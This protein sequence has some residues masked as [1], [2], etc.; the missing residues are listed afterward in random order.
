MGGAMSRSILRILGLLLS[1]LL[2]AASGI[3]QDKSSS[4]EPIWIF[5]PDLAIRNVDTADLNADGTADII[6]SEYSPDYYGDPSR[7]VALDGKTGDTLWTYLVQDGIRSLATG[8]INADGVA[9]VIAGASYHSAPPSD[10]F[11]HAIDGI[12]GQAIWTYYIGNS[13]TDITLANLNGDAYIDV[14]VASFDDYIH[15]IDGA[16]GSQLWK[17]YLGSLWVNAVSAGDVNGDLI[18]DIG[19]AHEYLAGYDNHCGV[20]DGSTGL[21]IWDST[22]IYGV[23]DVL[24]TDIDNDGVLEA[25]FSGEFNDDHAEI[26]IRNGAD[27]SLEW[28]YNLGQTS[29]L[30]SDINFY[31]YD[32]DGNGDQE[33][34]VANQYGSFLIYAFEGDNPS[35][36]WVSDTLN[37]YPKSL[38]FGD[39]TG[40]GEINIIAATYDRVQVLS[41]NGKKVW[42]Y[43]VAGG[44]EDVEVCDVDGD[45]VLDVIAGGSA[46]AVGLPPDPGK[47]VWALR[48]TTS[49]LLW[50]FNF[51][52]YGNG[53]ALGDFNND[54]CAD[55]IG[56][57]SLDDIAWAIDGKTG[58]E[59]WHWTGT[60][61]LYAVAVGDFDNNNQL[62]AVVAG[63]DEIISA[64]DGST[65]L[66]MWQF[67]NPTDQIYRSCL[68]CTDLNEDGNVDVIAGTDDNNVYAIRGED[69]SQLWVSSLGGEVSNVVLAQ[70]NGTGPLDIVVAVGGGPSGEKVAVLDGSDGSL[71]WEY[72]VSAA[73]AF[74]TTLD[75]NED[76]ILDVA[77]AIT[78]LGT[79]QIFVIDGLTHTQLWSQPM[80]VASNISGI[81]SGD[82]NFDKIDDIIVPGNSTDKAIHALNGAD[83]SE[84][85]SY[86]TGGEVN[87]VLA[88]DVDN[89]GVIE[90]IAGSDD[91]YVY[92]LNGPDGTA[93]WSFS[94]ADD[95]MDIEIAD[96]GCD[97]LPNIACITFGSDG[98]VYAFSTLAT[99]PLY[100]C[101][102]ANDDLMVNVA[103]AVFLINFVFKGGPPPDPIEAGDVNCDD[104]TNVGDAVYLINYVF[105]SG[106]IPCAVCQ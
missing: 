74:V 65:G 88:Y 66:T 90:V 86:P 37:G 32:L 48:T 98:I 44:I 75:V 79:K 61:N 28:S 93:E 80:P 14:V 54:N 39:V 85:W 15:A 29:I 95:V 10:G 40:D 72:P 12:T 63:A 103:D 30:S 6:A 41:D 18:D 60:Q 71:L 24:I 43:S 67:P 84:L 19:Y 87:A 33:L 57:C 52:E 8:D 78:P 3:A 104:L 35:V 96:I 11:V 51:G 27:G 23:L 25:I 64:I 47:G 105:K 5:D 4:G 34:I 59:L 9:D 70:M 38:A 77:G 73:V 62:D 22:V 36:L 49:P 91:Q 68:V 58:L 16:I 81:A 55:A 106:P 13:M 94:T 89:D 53:L 82:L 46:D 69:G 56:I 101:G 45:G 21:V 1:V 50:E 26:F 76:D 99:G 102:D 92:V 20:I 83:G 17:K 100:E 2:L 97:G 42:Y 7:V 31:E